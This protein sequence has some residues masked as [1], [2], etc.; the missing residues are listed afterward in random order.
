MRCVPGF[1]TVRFTLRG[2]VIQ[3]KVGLLYCAFSTDPRRQSGEVHC[4]EI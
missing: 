2:V 4:C 3:V 1:D